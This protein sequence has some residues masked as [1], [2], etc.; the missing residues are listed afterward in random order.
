MSISDLRFIKR[1]DE[2]CPKSDRVNI[3]SKTRGLYALLN[4]RP[5]LNKYDVVYIGMAAK[6][7]IKGRLRS[8]EKPPKGDLWTHF[9]IYEV[10]D[11]VTPPEVAELEGLL[12]HIYRKDARANKIAVQ[13]SFKKLTKVKTKLQNWRPA[14]THG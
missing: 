2:F 12:R 6:G 1:C 5:K 13:K 14:K 7:G 8:H 4:K 11:T 3:P 10:H 9:S